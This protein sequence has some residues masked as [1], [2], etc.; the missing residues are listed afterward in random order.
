[1]KRLGLIAIALIVLFSASAEAGKRKTKRLVYNAA[2]EVV[3]VVEEVKKAPASLDL[4]TV[5]FE[6]GELDTRLRLMYGRLTAEASHRFDPDLND[7]QSWFR[8]SW[9]TG[10]RYE[11]IVW[12]RED[13][14]LRRN[15]TMTFGVGLNVKLWER[16]R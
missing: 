6:D 7:D 5:Y 4:R 8:A 11:P 12:L 3:K 9:R 2:G 1:M 14:E 10:W 15:D 16:G 13:D